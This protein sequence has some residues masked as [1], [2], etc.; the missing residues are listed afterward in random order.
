MQIRS[1]EEVFEEIERCARAMLDLQL[2]KKA[3]DQELKELKQSFKEEGVPVTKVIK[4]LNR[5]KAKMKQ[6]DADRLEEEIIEERLE[7]NNDVQDM[8]SQLNN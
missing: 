2:Q 1:T 5:L 7:S 6:N 3:I 8:I 4:V